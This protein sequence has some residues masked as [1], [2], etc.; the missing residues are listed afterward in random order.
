[1]EHE[2]I[3]MR[4]DEQANQAEIM[5]DQRMRST[6]GKGVN[7]AIGIASGAAGARVLP[8]LSEYIPIDLAMKGLQKVSP[9]IA[10]FLKR[11]QSAGLNI[12]EGMEYVKEQLIPKEQT[13]QD[14]RNLVEMHSP[15]LHQFITQH[16][17]S[18]KSH[19]QAGALA[20][21]P[22]KEGDFNKVIEKLMKENNATW[23]DILE[24]VY[25][26]QQ[27]AQQSQQPT[28]QAPAQQPN[29]PQQQGQSGPGQQAL[30]DILSK[31]NQR[32]GQ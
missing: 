20:K 27:A 12:K 15:E 31:I 8:F 18:G 23:E 24:S 10:D 22:R 1:M 6:V 2:V 5:R 25:G 16:I 26:G 7:A 30:M 11:G 13:Q 32:M 4:P 17:K 29:Q 28:V 3:M 14:K 9:K 19:K 21:L